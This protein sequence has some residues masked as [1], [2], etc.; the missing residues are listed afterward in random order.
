MAAQTAQVKPEPEP[1]F[2][3]GTDEH[4][5][6]ND[7]PRKEPPRVADLTGITPICWPSNAPVSIA[8]QY[9]DVH[10]LK[11]EPGQS[12]L[13]LATPH[14]FVFERIDVH[15]VRPVEHPL[16]I[17]LHMGDDTELGTFSLKG[18]KSVCKSVSKLKPGSLLS[19]MNIFIR[20]QGKNKPEGG[21][22]LAIT[23]HGYLIEPWR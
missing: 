14:G 12:G 4:L 8:T 16:E 22:R 2:V 1:D 3:P 7:T 10:K 23:F 20:N 5:P 11:I 6:E 21:G 17:Q 18:E 19:R 13:L 15:A 9:C